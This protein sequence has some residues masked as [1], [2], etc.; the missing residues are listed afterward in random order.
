[1]I[2]TPDA[3]EAGIQ[4]ILAGRHV[5]ADVQMIES[6]SGRKRFQKHGGDLHCYIAD[7]DV[8]KEAKAQGT[9]VRLSPCKKQHVCMKAGFMPSEMRQRLC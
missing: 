2:I 3:I 6:G 7:E 8:A 9:T 5:V 4:S 1:M